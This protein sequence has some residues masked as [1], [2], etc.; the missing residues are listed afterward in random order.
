MTYIFIKEEA[1]GDSIK[2]IVHKGGL[3]EKE[4]LLGV[5][6]YSRESMPD[7]RFVTYHTVKRIL[8]IFNLCIFFLKKSSITPVACN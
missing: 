5:S 8:S 4:K 1:G 3:D 6:F 2:K 7:L